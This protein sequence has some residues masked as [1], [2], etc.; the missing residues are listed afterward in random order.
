MKTQ[1][2]KDRYGT[3]SGRVKAEITS[4]REE[5]MEQK[6]KGDAERDGREGREERRDGEDGGQRRAAGE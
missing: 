3:K 5:G 4:E 1:N 6:A 2:K